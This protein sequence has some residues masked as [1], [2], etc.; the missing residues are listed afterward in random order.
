M[1]L[2]RWRFRS[3]D[4]LSRLPQLR[5]QLDRFFPEYR[6][7]KSRP[8]RSTAS[9]SS[10]P[11]RALRHRER[12][13]CGRP[14]DAARRSQ[15]QEAHNPLNGTLSGSSLGSKSCR[16]RDR[17]PGFPRSSGIYPC[18][19][20]LRRSTCANRSSMLGSAKPEARIA[21]R[22]ASTAVSAALREAS[23]KL[24]AEG[25]VSLPPPG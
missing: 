17:T 3:C 23:S 21:S 7:T 16:F 12:S 25:D 10:P 14:P 6:R 2:A 19:T 5:Q 9:R 4:P 24:D 20:V 15:Q 8:I 22:P 13:R 11:L 18:G 1:P